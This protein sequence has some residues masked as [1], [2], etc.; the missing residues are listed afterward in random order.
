MESFGKQFGIGLI[1]GTS[2]IHRA[3]ISGLATL[4]GVRERA[5]AGLYLCVCDWWY[6]CAA[7]SEVVRVAQLLL[8]GG[9]AFVA[10]LLARAPRNNLQN[11]ESRFGRRGSA[12]LINWGKQTAIIAASRRARPQNASILTPWR[13]WHLRKAT[14]LSL[15]DA[16]DWQ[17]HRHKHLEWSFSLIVY[18]Y[19]EFGERRVDWVTFETN[20]KD[21][22]QRGKFLAFLL[23]YFHLEPKAD[24]GARFE[25]LLGKKFA[26][27]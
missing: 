12:Q 13:F 21:F 6:R 16:V 25:N 14:T 24:P 9:C 26:V 1:G 23:F 7:G 2:D 10:T 17:T 3:A 22:I 8:S 4:Q 15:R 5:S 20:S 19:Q 27:Q 18:F 11:E